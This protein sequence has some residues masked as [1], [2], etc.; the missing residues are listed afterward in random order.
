ME[1]AEKSDIPDI[2]KKKCVACLFNSSGLGDTCEEVLRWCAWLGLQVP[3]SVGL[4]SWSV[5]ICDSKEDQSQ[6]R[7]SNLHVCEERSASYW[8]ESA[9][10]IPMY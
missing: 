1:K 10:A 9:I 4:D 5:C 8:Y 3:C 2:D 6:P 7:E